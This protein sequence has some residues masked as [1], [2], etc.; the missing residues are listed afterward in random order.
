[1]TKQKYCEDMGFGWYCIKFKKNGT[2]K[3]DGGHS[4]RIQRTYGKWVKNGDTISCNPKLH[5]QIRPF[6]IIY[7]ATERSATYYLLSNDSIYSLDYNS[8][9]KRLEK[10]A[11]LKN[12]E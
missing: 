5:R 9:T 11:V 8:E 2:Y 1:M 12:W 3:E 4:Y 10:G 6:S 7:R